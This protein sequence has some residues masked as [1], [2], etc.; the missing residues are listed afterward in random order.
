[1]RLNASSS[2]YL[3]QLRNRLKQQ[4]PFSYLPEALVTSW[5]SDAKLL[6]LK[7][8]QTLVSNK[9]LQDRL[10]LVIDGKV[11]L[12]AEHDDDI[13][14]LKTSGPGQFLGW[15]SLLRAGACEW[16]TAS[17]SCV[18]LALKADKFLEYY[19]QVSSFSSWFN[20]LSQPQESF[21][22]VLAALNLAP[23]RLE[24]WRDQVLSN[25]DN[26]LITVLPA[27]QNLDRSDDS[28][29]ETRWFLSTPDVP[30]LPVG[31][32]SSRSCFANTLWL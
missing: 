6:R 20:N 8:G 4:V 11:R 21:Q 28:N 27:G 30:N 16:V 9:Q 32:E 19:N 5:F 22:V 29:G 15:V 17:E 12:L 25:L 23:Q 2:Q 13:K 31:T 14:T 26:T 18:V 10:Y 3:D 24:G 1:M 7:P